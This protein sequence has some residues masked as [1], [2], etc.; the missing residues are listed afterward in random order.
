MQD[1][2]LFL[3]LAEI[4]GVFVGF[5]ALIAVRSGGPTEAGEVT[6]I[7]WVM[8]N[9][10]WVVV[11]A[12]VPI[13]IGS[14]GL[15]G[16]ELWLVGSLLAL[17]L[18]AVIIA[19]HGGTR[20]PGRGCCRPCLD[21]KGDEGGAVRA[22]HLVARGA[23]PP[24]PHPRG[25]WS[26]PGSGA[27]AIPDGCRARPVHGRDGPVRHGLLAAT[28]SASVRPGGAARD[29]RL[30]RLARCRAPRSAHGWVTGASAPLLQAKMS[31]LG[32]RLQPSSEL[33]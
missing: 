14:Y 12:L 33:R 6:G 30:E 23:P 24:R 28:L 1:T 17:I 19:E 9:A 32:G 26:L 16:H 15:S 5:G 29:R 3:S 7:R 21:A 11:A 20:E 4:A 8:S 10:I 31:E 18:F 2:E 13:F 25:A 22:H 27:G